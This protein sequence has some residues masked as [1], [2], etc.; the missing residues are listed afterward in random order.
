MIV[1]TKRAIDNPF[2]VEYVV[3]ESLCLRSL[4]SRG[5]TF[6]TEQS[7]SPVQSHNVVGASIRL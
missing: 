5:D 1:L 2:L 6:R 7:A 3:F 4:Y